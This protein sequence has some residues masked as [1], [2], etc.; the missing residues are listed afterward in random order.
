MVTFD[1]YEHEAIELP[2]VAV[3]VAMGEDVAEI[4]MHSHP[5]G[6]IIVSLQGAVSCELRD[7]LWMVPPNCAVW[8][9]GHIEHRC[10]A[11]LNARMC[12][13]MI[14][15][16][17]AARLPSGCATLQ[18]TPFVRELILRM[19]Q[20]DQTNPEPHAMSMIDVVL[21]ELE[22]MKPASFDL[23][24]PA[25]PKLRLIVDTILSRPSDR[26]TLPEWADRLAMSERT[27]SR[28]IVQET[29]L[30]FGRW[31][32]QMHLLMALRMLASGAS[33][34][35]AANDLGYASVTAFITMFKSALGTTP[36]R[37]FQSQER[38]S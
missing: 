32:Q 38:V 6:Q 9:P 35:A 12:F 8:I 13:L 33:V 37:Y 10:R 19:T 22:Q 14:K 5:S 21:G 2:V 31:R 11:T 24:L 29:G 15:P 20:L 28:L 27:L 4:P 17:Y 1:L 25:N 36:T 26:R 7:A 30:S 16:D 34:Q 23:P 18:I 3:E